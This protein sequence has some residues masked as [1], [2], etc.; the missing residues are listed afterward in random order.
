MPCAPTF[1]SLDREPDEAATL[2]RWGVTRC[3]QV[4]REALTAA[5]AELMVDERPAPEGIPALI[6]HIRRRYHAAHAQALADAVAMAEA[7]EAA[8]RRDDAWPH[9][10]ADDL[11]RLRDDLEAHQQREAAVL[12]PALAR[13]PGGAAPAA[14][15]QSRTDHAGLAAQ[16]DALA[17]R[18]GGFA[19]PPH[20][21]V[22]WRLLYLLCRRLD[23]ELRAQMALEE[24]RLFQPDLRVCTEVKACA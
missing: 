6:L 10:L 17:G 13:D 9:G 21:C 1:D 16:L 19:P 15:A 11:L 22:T 12:F 5:L 7:A 24:T 2:R 23:M 18:T 3:D 20:A 8:H 14:V 4:E